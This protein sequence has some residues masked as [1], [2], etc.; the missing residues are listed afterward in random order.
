M[1][2]KGAQ[3][4]RFTW[5]SRIY[6]ILWRLGQ[7]YG[8]RRYNLYLTDR[9]RKPDTDR[10]RQYL[11]I[12]Q[13][14]QQHSDGQQPL[15]R[16]SGGYDTLYGMGGK[17]TLSGGNGNEHLNGGDGDDYIAGGSGSDTII[18]GAGRDTVPFTAADIREGSIDRVVEFDPNTDKLDL[19]G[20]RS[21]LTG[22]NAN[23]SWSKM[24]V[25]K[26]PEVI[27]Q[28]DHPYLIFDTEQQTLAYRAAGSSSS[29]VFAKFDS[30]DPSKWLHASNIIG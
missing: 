4:W 14:L 12:W 2:S 27:L 20:M 6:H 19:S 7:R 10:R 16:L 21:L 26:D 3:Q 13:Q 24:F 17:D 18:T 9:R 28:K 1:R 25:D 30:D 23:L 5:N 8:L 15:D 11:W 29:T 22:S